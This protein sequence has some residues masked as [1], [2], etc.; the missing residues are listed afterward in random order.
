MGIPNQ[1][2]NKTMGFKRPCL[3]CGTLV[4]KG[5]RCQK[6][7]SEYIAKLDQ[8]RKPNR[9][10]YSSDYRKRAKQV[11]ETATICWLCKQPFTD[12]KQIT[13]D[14]YYPGVPD[15]PLLPAHKS[16]NSSRGNNPPTA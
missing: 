5:N 14:H 6:H 7:Q 4:E 16:C 1:W 2:D 3:N 11:R 9:T 10:H 12:K 13:A 15:S 8:K